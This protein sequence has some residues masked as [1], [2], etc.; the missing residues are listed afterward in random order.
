MKSMIK[1][2]LVAIVAFT[3]STATSA[4]E[5]KILAGGGLSYA[6][7][8]NNIGLFAK[9]IY[10][11]ND[12]WEGA[13]T[14]TY[15][16]KKDYTTWTALDFNGH[17]VFSSNETT[18]FYALGGLNMTF[19]KVKI[20][21]VT[22]DMESVWGAGYTGDEM[23]E[24]DPYSEMQSTFNSSIESSG[25]EIGFNIGIGGRYALTE[26]LYLNGEAKYTLGGADYFN[27]AAGL[28]YRF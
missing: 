14:F 19:Y 16:F 6:S 10:L 8:I 27:I 11:I 9:G 17:Y 24:F 7:E 20:D 22:Y 5:S 3:L 12:S 2:A 1:L 28:M 15:F 25:S 18:S 21:A 4:Q 26:S 23:S 13:G